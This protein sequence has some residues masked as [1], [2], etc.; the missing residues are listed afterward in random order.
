MDS[1]IGFVPSNL[2]AGGQTDIK[3][4]PCDILGSLK[5]SKHQA[6]KLVVAT[7]P[8]FLSY[9]GSLFIFIFILTHRFIKDDH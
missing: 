9:Q 1:K 8:D 7:T 6:G 5:A 2:R 4:V 3:R